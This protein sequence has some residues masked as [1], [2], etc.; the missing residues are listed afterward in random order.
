VGRAKGWTDFANHVQC[1]R[2]TYDA[3]AL[4]CH[5]YG[6]AS[7]IT[8]YLPDHPTTFLPPKPYGKSQFTLWPGYNVQSD[9]RALYVTT[10]G[11]PPPETLQQQFSDVQLVDDFWSQHNGRPMTHF[12]IYLCRHTGGTPSASPPEGGLRKDHAS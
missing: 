4:I 10:P 1:A 12:R 11:N 8:F 5:H 2:K 6:H 9:T 7:L 3:N